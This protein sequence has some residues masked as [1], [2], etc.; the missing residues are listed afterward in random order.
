MPSILIQPTLREAG[1]L[2]AD[3]KGHERFG[4]EASLDPRMNINIVGQGQSF[5]KGGYVSLRRGPDFNEAGSRIVD[6]F[7]YNE[8]HEDS[9][10]GQLVAASFTV[11][12]F[13]EETAFDRLLARVHWGLPDITLEFSMHSDVVAYDNS[14]PEPFDLIF[15]PNPRP[16]EE[17]NRPG[18]SGGSIL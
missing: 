14:S 6:E 15:S 11:I 13:V 16:W 1:V 5:P 17:V 18:F 4:F 3:I 2:V 12:L 7:R 10:T 8:A 9:D